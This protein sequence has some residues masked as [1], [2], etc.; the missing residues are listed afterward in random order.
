[1]TKKVTAGEQEVL[2]FLDELKDSGERNMLDK[3]AQVIEDEF[4]YVR[5]ES[6]RLYKLWLEAQ[7][8]KENNL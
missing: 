3:I 5:E 1:M 4:G 6:K 7:N 2:D 8:E